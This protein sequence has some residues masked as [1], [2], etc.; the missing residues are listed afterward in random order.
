MGHSAFSLGDEYEEPGLAAPASEPLYPNITISTLRANGKWGDLI[1][2]A[3]LVPSS[4]NPGCGNFAVL[5]AAPAGAVGAFEGG[6]HSVC[7]VFRP[8]A[9]CRMPTMTIRSVPSASA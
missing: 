7:G 4:R 9:Q 3:T 8:A 2:Q 6:G 5:A 1:Q